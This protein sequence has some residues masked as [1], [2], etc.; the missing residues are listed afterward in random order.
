MNL[1]PSF[2]REGNEH[3]RPIIEIRKYFSEALVACHSDFHPS[4][5]FF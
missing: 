4:L 3:L 2:V 1:G 5:R